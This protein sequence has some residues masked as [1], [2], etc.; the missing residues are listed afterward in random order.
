MKI[1]Y[2]LF[3]LFIVSFQATSQERQKQIPA[4][5][6]TARIVKFYPNPATSVINFDIQKATDKIYNFQIYSLTGKKVFE[7]AKVD[8]KTSVNLGDFYRGIYV[9]QLKDQNGKLVDS[10]KFQVSK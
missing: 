2:S 1:F 5:E 7:L 9:F 8:A 10:G 6:P 3:F 4:P